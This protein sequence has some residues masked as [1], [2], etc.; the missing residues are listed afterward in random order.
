MY[1]CSMFEAL[2]HE[3]EHIDTEADLDA[4]AALFAVQDTLQAR[5]CAMVGALDTCGACEASGATS[6]TAWLQHVARRSG[7]EAARIVK[8]ARMLR[9]F[10]TVHDAWLDGR[11]STAHVEIV[12]ANVKRRHYELFALSVPD[13]L[14]FLVDLDVPQTRQAM[15]AWASLADDLVPGPDDDDPDNALYLSRSLDDRGVLKGTL[16]PDA[17]A[18]MEAALALF[19]SGDLE[20][21]AAQRRADALEAIAQFALDHHDKTTGRRNRPHVS[22][23]MREGP[24]GQPVARTLTGHPISRARL[25]QW[26]CDGLL[27]RIMT[28]EG[29]VLDH[30]RSVPTISP[31]L[32]RAL[33]A[34]DCGCR[35]PGCTR[36]ASWY[37]AHHVVPFSDGGDTSISNLGLFCG[38]HHRLL[39]KGTG[40]KASMHADASIDFVSPS[41][42]LT[43]TY[44]P[45]H[46]RMLWPPG[47]DPPP[48]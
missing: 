11:L 36:P 10:P 1:D 41:G 45:G 29:Q 38:H 21:P 2:A 33:A 16:D 22:V 39:H 13:L 4:V 26:I 6:I 5:L 9:H 15:S 12:V 28:A 44:P 8:A 19:D 20:V 31:A 7:G 32:W 34:R 47:N 48:P 3:I 42:E 35:F 14:P 17:T 23:V 24:D 40:W 27:D 25:R 37:E 46:P 18:V 43:T 30:G